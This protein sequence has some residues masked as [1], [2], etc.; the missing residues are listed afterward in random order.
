MPMAVLPADVWIP[1]V[2]IVAIVTSGSIPTAISDS[3][4]KS[5]LLTTFMKLL[6]TAIQ[7]VRN[8]AGQLTRGRCV[9]RSARSVNSAF[10]GLSDA[11]LSS[12]RCGSFPACDR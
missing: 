11:Q 1:R 5:R 9:N 3:M 4:P 8:Q 10:D 2:S 12:F 6:Y 7:T